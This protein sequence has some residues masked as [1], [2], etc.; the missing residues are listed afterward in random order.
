MN[1]LKLILS[2]PKYFAPAWVFAS[3]NI[4]TGT[5]VLYLPFIKNKFALND[6]QIGV[7]LFCTAIGLLASIPFIPTVSKKN[8]CRIDYK[9]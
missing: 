4:L 1:S 5:W 2:N 9:I 3:L 6:A 7:A 8:G